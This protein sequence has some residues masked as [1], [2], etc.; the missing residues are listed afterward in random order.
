MSQHSVDP[1]S[2]AQ[3]SITTWFLSSAFSSLDS[4]QSFDS[5]LRPRSELPT[6]S[7]DWQECPELDTSTSEDIFVADLTANVDCE[8]EARWTLQDLSGVAEL[9]VSDDRPQY[10]FHIVSILP[11]KMAGPTLMGFRN[12]HAPFIRSCSLHSLT[13]RLLSSRRALLRKRQSS[14]SFLPL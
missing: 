11:G 12:S 4:F 8:R 1:S 7:Q 14:V 9:P 10:N 3:T 5:L 13:V 6:R 2:S